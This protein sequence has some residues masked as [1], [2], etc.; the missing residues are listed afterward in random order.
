MNLFAIYTCNYD[1]LCFRNVGIST[2]ALIMSWYEGNDK[3]DWHP[4]DMEIVVPCLFEEVTNSYA[5]ETK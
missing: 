4:N 1:V 3:C 5:L 2:Q